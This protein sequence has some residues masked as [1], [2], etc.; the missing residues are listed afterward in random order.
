MFRLILKYIAICCISLQSQ[1][2][3]VSLINQSQLYSGR[4]LVHTSP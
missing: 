2:V 4:E 1:D 3:S